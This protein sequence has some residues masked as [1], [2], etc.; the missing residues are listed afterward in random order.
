M[1]AFTPRDRRALWLGA[2]LVVPVLTWRVLVTPL[3]ST[4]ATNAA[5]AELAIGLLARERALLRDGPR[6]PVVLDSAR[7]RLRTEAASYFIARDTVAALR[8]LVASL[9]TAARDAGLAGVIVE[10]APARHVTSAMMEVQADVRAHGST[11]A[12]SSWLARLEDGGRVLPVD[13]LDLFADGDGRLAISA[14]VRGFARM[15]AP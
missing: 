4:S 11:A 13:R 8:A 5:R 10:G 6:L 15:A 9:R 7:G 3:A 2:L 12:L 14:R 1:R